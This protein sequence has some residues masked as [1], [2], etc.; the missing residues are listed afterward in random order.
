MDIDSPV[1]YGSLVE[2][3]QRILEDLSSL[4][5]DFASRRVNETTQTERKALAK[6]VYELAAIE[7]RLGQAQDAPPDED[8]D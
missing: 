3:I 2:R 1:G 8:E 6:A 4:V 5:E 7:E